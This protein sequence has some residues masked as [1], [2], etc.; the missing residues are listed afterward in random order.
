[1][2][3]ATLG[4]L[5]HSTLDAGPY[6]S[7]F[8]FRPNLCREPVWFEGALK[9]PLRFREAMSALHEVVVS[10]LR[11]VKRDR[12]A[13]EEYK[14]RKKDEERALRKELLEKAYSEAEPGDFPP[15]LEQ[16]FRKLH[17]R[18]WTVRRT[19]ARELMKTD[20]ELWR[21]L[22][23]CD[24]VV[25]VAPDVVLFEGFSKDESSYGCV[26]MDRDLL[27]GGGEASMGTTNVDYSIA[28]YEHF[29]TL[30]TYRESRLH[31]DPQGFEVSVEGHEDYREEKID[32]PP[33]WLRGFGQISAAT[34]LPARRVSL[35]AHAIYSVLAHLERHREK[36][37]PRSI[38]FTLTPG[39]PPVMTLEP[40][41][42]TIV[43]RGAPYRGPAPEEIRIWGRRRLRV[44]RR[45]LPLLE[46]VDVHLLGSG[47][48]SL[49][50]AHLGPIRFVLG[51][52]GW[53]TNDW[54]SGAQLDLL[55]D[56]FEPDE[57]TM[58]ELATYLYRERYAK[59]STLKQLCPVP[60]GT[61]VPEKRILGSLHRLAK[62]G[63]IIYDFAAE[64]YRYRQILPEALGEE[65][66]GPEPEEVTQGRKLFVAK[67]VK[68]L[69]NVVESDKRVVSAS[70]Q[71]TKCEALLD[72]D[73]R[74]LRARC[75]CSHHQKFGL[76]KGPCRHLLATRLHLRGD[77]S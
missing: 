61:A 55:A 28:L 15:D 2:T 13:Y 30:R 19:W 44:L 39:K 42:T 23:P 76:K 35:P 12:T 47:L 29:Q 64:V 77:A 9:D 1:M 32:L 37:G 71:G 50:V 43:S 16:R 18:Y 21:H 38:R 65:Q 57:Q 58:N 33:S 17:R 69:K 14:K 45:V 26:T 31:V 3:T 8:Q 41:G 20:P 74:F 49:W 63:Q 53:T 27:V 10:D 72:L 46:R 59:L 52:S 40:W 34:G 36:H 25:T 7:T 62:R 6:R 51:L 68:I 67:K 11:H 60:E 48:P 54:S 4:Y 56:A 75:V 22:V 66:L 24:P 73:G 5:G 70:V